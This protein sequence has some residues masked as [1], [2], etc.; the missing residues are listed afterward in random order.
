MPPKVR[1]AVPPV[2]MA[3]QPDSPP[4]EPPETQRAAKP[5]EPPKKM[6][7]KAHGK[8][9]APAG[10]GRPSKV[11]LVKHAIAKRILMHP[12]VVQKVLDALDTVAAKCLKTQGFF[13][14]NFI[15][16]RLRTQ[17]ARGASEK[18]IC[19]KDVQLKAKPE[20]RTLK[21]TPAKCLKALCQ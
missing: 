11:A 17:K 7:G 16:V 8:G 3:T 12:D 19:G 9:K 2:A 18:R 6:R 21:A 4:D 20:R 1:T 15:T 13:R 10:K 5:A 14:L